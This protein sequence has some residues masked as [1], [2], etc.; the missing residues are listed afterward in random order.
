MQCQIEIMKILQAKGYNPY[1][2]GIQ[3]MALLE[4]IRPENRKFLRILKQ[5]IDPG[6]ILNTSKYID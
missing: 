4:N 5:T 2:L 6:L 3:S 1:R